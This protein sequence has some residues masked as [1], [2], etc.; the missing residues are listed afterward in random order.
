[1][2]RKIKNYSKRWASLKPSEKA[3]RVR[4]LEALRLMKEGRS[5]SN[6]SKSVGISPRTAKSQL[7]RVLFKRKYRWHARPKDRVERGLI[8]YEMGRIVQIVVR[9]SETASLLGQYLNDAKKA[10]VSG[11]KSV[12]KR[13]KKVTIT[14][15]N[16]KKHRLE[17]RLEKIKMIELSREDIEF[18][19]I[20]AY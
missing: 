5:L 17:T 15:A 9:D 4:A 7:G 12:L 13:Y 19:D 10:L 11:D 3:T 16:G 2:A 1:M 20:Y 18:S 8:I 6:A 14:D